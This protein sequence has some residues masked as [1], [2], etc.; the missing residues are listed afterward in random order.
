ML[1]APSLRHEVSRSALKEFSEASEKLREAETG[2]GAMKR[3]H[4]RA[5]VEQSVKQATTYGAP[6]ARSPTRADRAEPSL[7]GLRLLRFPPSE[8]GTS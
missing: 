7:T 5:S 6:S 4:S 1:I 3:R 2:L 8:D